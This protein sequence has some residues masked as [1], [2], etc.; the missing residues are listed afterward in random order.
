M[1]V[2]FLFGPISRVAYFFLTYLIISIPMISNGFKQETIITYL[3]YIF[4][5]FSFLY[6]LFYIT[7]Y[8][9]YAFLPCKSVIFR[10]FKN[11]F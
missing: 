4:L 9:D 8:G 10:V 7:P 6:G 3:L 11:A 2:F 5:F 1:N